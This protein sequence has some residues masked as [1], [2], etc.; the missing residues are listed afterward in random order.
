MEFNFVL[1]LD[2]SFKLMLKCK[3]NLVLHSEV[4]YTQDPLVPS[5][6]LN[7]LSDLLIL[8]LVSVRLAEFETKV[9]A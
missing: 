2:Q 9:L 8:T 4:L 1:Q 5:I 6:N 3:T 7:P